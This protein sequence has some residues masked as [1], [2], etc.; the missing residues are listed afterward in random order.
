MVSQEATCAWP[1]SM[2]SQW[3]GG[4]VQVVLKESDPGSTFWVGNLKHKDIQGHLVEE[5]EREDEDDEEDNSATEDDPD[6][7]QHE[8]QDSEGEDEGDENAEDMNQ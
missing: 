3:F 7:A 4:A 2:N 5:V 6:V 1:N 8:A